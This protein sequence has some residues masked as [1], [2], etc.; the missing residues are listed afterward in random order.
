MTIRKFAWVTVG[1]VLLFIFIFLLWRYQLFAMNTRTSNE[2]T[3]MNNTVNVGE[4]RKNYEDSKEF[5]LFDKE[6]LATRALLK[7]SSIQK[8]HNLDMEVSYV[9]LDQDGKSTEDEKNIRSIQMEVRYMRLG[10]VVSK[11][12][13]RFAI[14]ELAKGG[15]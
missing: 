2:F 1:V 10:Q 12:V 5:V 7:I 4:V 14:D 3:V 13:N 8:E 15:A 6:E 11:V 9:F